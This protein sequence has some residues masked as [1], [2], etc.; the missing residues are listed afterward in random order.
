MSKHASAHS[1]DRAFKVIILTAFLDILGLG[2]L[3][4][5]LPPIV[6]D[7]A[8][9]AAAGLDP[10]GAVLFHF[11]GS[12]VSDPA[13]LA[14]GLAFSLFSLGM[15]IGG[16]TFGSLSD[17]IGRKKTLLFT[18]S[19]GIAGY[20]FFGLSSSILAFLAGRFL[21]G[22]AGGGFP[23]TQAY[24]GD[25]YDPKE[26]AVKMGMVGAAFGAG[27]TIGPALGGFISGFG[28]HT[29]GLISAAVM[30]VD[31]ALIYF[32]LPEPKHHEWHAK[33]PEHE[34]SSPFPWGELLPVYAVAS[35]VALGFSGMQSTFGFVLPDRFHVS[36]QA[37]GYALGI[38]GLTSIAFQGYLIRYVRAV[39][40]EKGMLLFGL[41]VMT[42]AF[43]LFSVN[44]FTVAAFAIPTLFSIGFGSVNV[45]TSALISRIAP[46]HAGRALGT[47]GS[48]MSLANIFGPL[49]A[50]AL[51]S[52]QFSIYGTPV[53]FWTYAASACF[54]A[55]ALPIAYFG[56]SSHHPIFAHKA[57]LP[58]DNA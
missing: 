46:G 9:R 55:L 50:N 39:F 28:L 2:L 5:V 21:S 3:I 57:P 53:G 18:A 15:L 1:A 41:S 8:E 58:Q 33:R 4:P 11:L 35:A 43:A 25:L 36:Q 44:P 13:A 42:L 14:N 7:F 19:L 37:V 48:A 17:R 6:R 31:L 20:L 23:V 38:V 52:I 34:T 27:F 16:I 54:F 51:Y 12:V 49:V 45:S 26:R 10:S 47:N 56:I 40:L 24:I 32:V 30:L 29:V 22:L